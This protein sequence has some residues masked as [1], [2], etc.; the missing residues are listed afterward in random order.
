MPLPENESADP[1]AAVPVKQWL[2]SEQR[3]LRKWTAMLRQGTPAAQDSAR[4]GL[5]LQASSFAHE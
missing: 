4:T 3:L 2:D 5:K 1:L